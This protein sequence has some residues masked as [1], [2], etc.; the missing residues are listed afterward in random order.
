MKRSDFTCLHQFSLLAQFAIILLN[1]FFFN[2]FLTDTFFFQLPRNDSNQTNEN[3]SWDVSDTP[4]SDKQKTDKIITDLKKTIRELENEKQELVSSLDLLDTEHQLNT[5][6]LINLKEKLQENYNDL[7]DK[8]LVLKKNNE[9]LQENRKVIKN[10]LDDLKLKYEAVLE[11]SVPQKETNQSNSNCDKCENLLKENQKLVS[12]LEIFKN[13]I[14]VLKSNNATLQ[15]VFDDSKN[16]NDLELGELEEKLKLCESENKILVTELKKATQSV[17][18]FE[19]KSEIDKE[20]C[21]K[22]ALI[23]EGYEQEVSSLK[24]KLSVKKDN[25]E[26]FNKLKTELEEVRE[27]LKKV[28]TAK[29]Q[30]HMKYINILTENM[31]KYADCDKPSEEISNSSCDDDPQVSEF[32]HQVESI[33][34]ILLDLKCKCESLENELFNVTQEKTNML[35]EKN[36]EIEKLM[37]NSEILS[38]EVIRKS[39]TIKDYESECSELI[40]NNDMLINELEMYKNSSGLQTISESNEDNIL[41]LES[42]LENANKKIEELEKI[43]ADMEKKSSKEEVKEEKTNETNNEV[44]NELKKTNFALESELEKLQEANL[45]M[46]D[47]NQKLKTDL[48]NTEYQYTEMNVNMETLKE[49]VENYKKK[50]E[51]LIEQKLSL[52]KLNLEYERSCEDSRTELNTIREKLLFEE[53]TRK[54]LESQIRSITEKLQNAKMCETSLK[55]QYDTV[56]KELVGLNEAKMMAEAHLQNS[57]ANLNHCQNDVLKYQQENEKLK[58][59]LIALENELEN[60]KKEVSTNFQ[61]VSIENEDNTDLKKLEEEKAKLSNNL[62]QLKLLYESVMHEKSNLQLEIEKLSSISK[63]HSTCHQ[64]ITS[65]EKKIEELSAAKNELTNVIITKHQESVTYHNEIQRLSQLI[66]V[67]LEKNRN[68]EAELQAKLLSVDS[69]EIEKKNEE[70]E[71]LTDQNNFLRQKCEVLAENLLQEQSKVQQILAEQNMPSEKE[72][73]LSKKLERLQT[74]LIEV[75]E[76]Y[77]QELLRAEERNTELQ[78]KVNEIEQR[79]KNSSTMY[80]SVSIRANQHVETLQH[81]LQLITNQ[82]DELRKKISDAEDHA[83]KQEAALANLQFVLEQFQKGKAY[84]KL[85]VL[86]HKIMNESSNSSF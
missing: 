80:T 22:L 34:N 14:A 71:K 75:E 55:L 52:E 84:S 85:L 15:K 12:E 31:K 32:S 27:D 20:H 64:T 62:D 21:R 25:S 49:E 63:E 17:S 65:L 33:L 57:L 2:F 10:Q 59:K 54:Q 60:R 72:Q 70:I 56:N 30:M 24:E 41:L 76:H 1:N 42:Q 48:E 35:S 11:N 82:R 43:I 26:D 50:N 44:L 18:E 40:K 37:Q 69:S 79:E 4:E 38:Q 51:E 5:E 39:Q 81:Q 73:V 19:K 61:D 7:E 28:V 74:H 66:S 23:L 46:N 77:T 3:W 67:E 58:E 45:S 36:H 6:K 29:H 68:L 47:E 8:Y 9:T 16:A 83:S 53:D 86:S 78:V 13:E